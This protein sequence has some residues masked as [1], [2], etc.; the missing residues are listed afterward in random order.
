MNLIVGFLFLIIVGFALRWALRLDLQSKAER[1][2]AD[3]LGHKRLAIYN[4][5]FQEVET[6]LSIL[7]VALNDAIEERDAGHDEIAWRMVQLAASE[8]ER[9]ESVIGAL[10]DALEKYFRFSRAVVPYRGML[11][12]RFK[13][14]AMIDFLRF[15][16]LLDRLLFRS[17]MR[18]HFQIRMLR[19]A[20]NNLSA[21][22][23][24]VYQYGEGTEVRPPG[25]WEHLDVYAHDFDVV[26]KETLLA[27]R[28]F[29]I[30][31]PHSSLDGFTADLQPVF[32]RAARTAPVLTET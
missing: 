25:L 29:L 13:S 20:T 17:R 23:Q 12:R 8:W 7:G 21:E 32:R 15:Q 27:L 2:A 14:Q 30:C 4:A 6:Q 18:F 16:D 28:A 3:V 5:I 22:F 9:V 11:A 24:K 19:K 10:L 1:G 31:L 26:T